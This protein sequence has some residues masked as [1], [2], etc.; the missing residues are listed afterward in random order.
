MEAV[1]ATMVDTRLIGRLQ[2]NAV[3]D[4]RQVA[5]QPVYADWWSAQWSRHPDA[6]NSVRIRNRWRDTS[7]R[8]VATSAGADHGGGNA[9]PEEYLWREVPVQ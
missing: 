4:Q 1:V 8:C 3:L 9:G 6:N 2:V 5:G 7:L